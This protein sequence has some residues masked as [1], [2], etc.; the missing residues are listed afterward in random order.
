M[1]D[2]HTYDEKMARKGRTKVIY[3]GTFISDRFILIDL[4]DFSKNTLIT[5][6]YKIPND[7]ILTYLFSAT[8]LFVH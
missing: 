4:D 6:T 5:L 8:V 3:K 7:T 1:K 2:E